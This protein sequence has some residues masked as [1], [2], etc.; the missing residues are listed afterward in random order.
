MRKVAL[1]IGLL[2]LAVVAGKDN[3]KCVVNDIDMCG[4]KTHE[5]MMK[6]LIEIEKKYPD[7][8]KVKFCAFFLISL[9][10]THK[11]CSNNFLITVSYFWSNNS[12]LNQY[13]DC[14]LIQYFCYGYT[15]FAQLK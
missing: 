4:Y 6:F 10:E 7:I 8:A 13:L 2:M 15:I 11:K 14:G 9:K 1:T 5:Q 12:W 3:S